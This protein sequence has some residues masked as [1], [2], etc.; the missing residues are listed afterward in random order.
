MEGMKS[1][2]KLKRSVT[3]GEEV[4]GWSRGEVSNFRDQDMQ[5]LRARLLKV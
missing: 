1:L 2:L 3:L 5:S 4:E